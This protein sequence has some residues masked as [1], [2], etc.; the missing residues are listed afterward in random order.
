MH[1]LIL[2]LDEWDVVHN[3]LNSE[4]SVN[5]SLSHIFDGAIDSNYNLQ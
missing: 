4:N 3:E 1:P 5:P 2:A